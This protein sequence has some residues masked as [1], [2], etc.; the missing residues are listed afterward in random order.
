MKSQDASALA[1]ALDDEATPGLWS[2]RAPSG[3][4]A[5]MV[6]AT[7]RDCVA[8]LSRMERGLGL[9]RDGW[10]IV[11]VQI[12]ALANDHPINETF[13]ALIGEAGR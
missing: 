3:A 6:W 5:A 11:P 7:P 8:T 12:V 4:I 13:A 9:L 2:I 1:D 10:R